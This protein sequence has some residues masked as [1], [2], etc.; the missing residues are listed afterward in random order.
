MSVRW[1][2]ISEEKGMPGEEGSG[3]GVGGNEVAHDLCEEQSD[4]PTGNSKN[5]GAWVRQRGLNPSWSRQNRRKDTARFGG[6]L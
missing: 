5:G 6:L 3:A 4:A 2:D 1:Q